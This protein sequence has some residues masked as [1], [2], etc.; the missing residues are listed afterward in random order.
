MHPPD[1]YQEQTVYLLG[2]F[3]IIFSE[4]RALCIA[5]ND[6]LHHVVLYTWNV[7]A[8]FYANAYL[9]FSILFQSYLRPAD[10]SLVF[11]LRRPILSLKMCF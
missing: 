10:N 11:D 3:V 2:F 5:L 8:D 6:A 4:L 7:E 9:R 1:G